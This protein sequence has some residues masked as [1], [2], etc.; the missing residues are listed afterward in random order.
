MKIYLAGSNR[1]D[2]IENML[3]KKHGNRLHSFYYKE[4]VLKL[5]RLRKKNENKG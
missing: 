2:E 5:F 3:I 1:T 4:E